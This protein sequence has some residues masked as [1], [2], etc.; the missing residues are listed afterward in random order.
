MNQSDEQRPGECSSRDAEMN[1]EQERQALAEDI[2]VLI[3]RQHQ[4]NRAGK[5]ATQE[6]QPPPP[7][8][9]NNSSSSRTSAE[10]GG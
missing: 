4:R 9:P 1:L 3:V 7:D 8:C 10:D 2:A 5:S 6:S